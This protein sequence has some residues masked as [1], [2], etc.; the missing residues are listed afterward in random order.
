MDAIEAHG[1][2]TAIARALAAEL[3][4][5]RRELAAEIE[6]AISVPGA[7]DAWKTQAGKTMKGINL[8][9]KDLRKLANEL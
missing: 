9:I 3:D 7:P 1:L 2:K 5:A 6:A 4:R 8:V